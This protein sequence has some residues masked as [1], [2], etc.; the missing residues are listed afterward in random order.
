MKNIIKVLFISVLLTTTLFISGCKSNSDKDSC[1]YI[2]YSLAVE[3]GYKES[4]NQW[5]DDLENNCL[6]FRMVDSNI[7]WTLNNSNWN[8]LYDYKESNDFWY[9]EF[10]SG[11]VFEYSQY[12]T[13]SFNTN[14]SSTINSQLVLKG[15]KAVKPSNPIKENYIFTGWFNNNVLFNLEETTINSTI[16]LEAMYEGSLLEVKEFI[17]VDSYYYLE[18]SNQ[19]SSLDLN[20][21]IQGTATWH[22]ID[23]SN[24]VVNLNQGVNTFYVLSKLG[25]NEEVTYEL[26]VKRLSVFEVEVN[27]FIDDVLIDTII[28]HKDENY[29]Y[30]MT[31]ITMAGYTLNY[32][33]D[34]V[35][36]VSDI[37]I[38]LN[39]YSNEYTITYDFDGGYSSSD[40]VITVKYN[41]EVKLTTPNRFGYSFTGWLLN[42]Q[43]VEQ[44]FMYTYINNIELVAN[45]EANKYTLTY[46]TTGVF[47]GETQVEVF[48]QQE[49][50]LTPTSKFGYTFDG[51]K[52][53]TNTFKGET[54]IYDFAESI[55][56]TASFT[57]T[58]L[59]ITYE[60]YGGTNGDNPSIA[61]VLTDHTLV[62][63]TKEG[64]TFSHWYYGS[65]VNNIVSKIDVTI[66]TVYNA[67]WILNN[68][69]YNELEVEIIDSSISSVVTI[70]FSL[71]YYINIVGLNNTKLDAHRIIVSIE[72]SGYSKEFNLNSY[73]ITTENGKLELFDILPKNV[74]TYNVDVTIYTNVNG[75]EEEVAVLNTIVYEI[76]PVEINLTCDN[77]G[78]ALIGE[79]LSCISI[80]DGYDEISNLMDELI[81]LAGNAYYLDRTLLDVSNDY[82]LKVVNLKDSSLWRYTFYDNSSQEVNQ[83]NKSGMYFVEIEFL[84]FDNY[85]PITS[86]ASKISFRVYDRLGINKNAISVRALN[87]N[88]STNQI[89]YNNP[90]YVHLDNIDIFSPHYY[91]INI[92]VKSNSSSQVLCEYDYNQLTKEQASELLP[93][94]IGEYTIYLSLVCFND[95]RPYDTVERIYSIV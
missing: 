59:E 67:H 54:M 2:T 1:E 76:T 91:E 52:Y 49:I 17:Q 26:R 68:N 82:S 36:V 23:N 24:K 33:V 70:E 41:T 69:Y 38:D 93:T 63:P 45:W 8:K 58:E 43:V 20:N 5:K 16:N 12:Y 47:V 39:F 50:N 34:K 21:Y 79:V 32:S 15:D 84:G 75:I 56:L 55:T 11:E 13:V 42:G 65:D 83:I 7:E 90:Y 51:W 78:K 85:T 66:S 30:D 87:E 25:T 94:D 40:S 37:V 31:T 89:D 86:K 44:T 9:Y 62:N 92:T 46:V 27:T 53:K 4:Y 71:D 48:Y 88:I 10:T 72:G 60:L 95:N 73:D 57:A 35:V 80:V 6:S 19:T 28:E 18:V 74:G 81:A 22:L 77:Q 14:N 29:E 64:S 61:T 3:N